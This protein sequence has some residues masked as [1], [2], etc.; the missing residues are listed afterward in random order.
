MSLN[1]V[2]QGGQPSTGASILQAIAKIGAGGGQALGNA[3]Q[4][5]G[6]PLAFQAQ[7]QQGLEQ[8]REDFQSKQG[9]MLT[10]YQQAV[11]NQQQQAHIDELNR[12]LNLGIAGGEFDPAS[13]VGHLIPHIKPQPSIY[14]VTPDS[15]IGKELGLTGPINVS[16]DK[17][18]DYALNFQGKADAKAEVEKQKQVVNDR[19]DQTASQLNTEIDSRFDPQRFMKLYG[20][21][22]DPDLANDAKNFHSQVIS[23]SATDKKMGNTT[24]IDQLAKQIREYSSTWEKQQQALMK[25]KADQLD[26]RNDQNWQF[27]TQ[28]LDRER[29]P[30]DDYAARF[31]RLRDALN[32]HLPP[33][34][35]LI[36]AELLTV[37]A[38]GQGSGLRVNEAEIL[39]AL[40]GQ[41]NWQTIKAALQKWNVDP[42]K[43]LSITEEQRG[44][45][46]DLLNIV[47]AKIHQ[48]QDIFYRT[49]NNLVGAQNNFTR[50]RA[51][52]KMHGDLDAV[53]SSNLDPR[54]LKPIQDIGSPY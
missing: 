23:A 8:M 44:Y 12:Q 39:R 43:A 35:S 42:S 24:Q 48:K 52:A 20:S 5:Q 29:K 32:S 22:D 41:S 10:A 13:T 18:L 3:M 53:D 51:M 33:A 47:G 27:N 25:T 45:L 49:E 31:S 11:L 1:N 26:H 46:N 34:D 50:D 17:Y 37:M 6:N 21:A 28:R 9:G 7:Q 36:P 40:H 16:A 4:A 38:G 30:L 19:I 54:T 14:Q 15:A 2:G